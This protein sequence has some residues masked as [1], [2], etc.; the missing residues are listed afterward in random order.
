MGTA[1]LCAPD[2]S[3]PLPTV[4]EL[5]A[6]RAVR[7]LPQAEWGK[8]LQLP[9][10]CDGV[11][12]TLA[13]Q[14]SVIVVE[15]I[16][17]RITAYWMIFTCVHVE[18]LWIAPEDR[19]RVGVIRKL[20]RTVRE[21]LRAQGVEIAFALINKANPAARYAQRLGFRRT[22]GDC[23]FVLAKNPDPVFVA[24]VEQYAAAQAHETH[25]TREPRAS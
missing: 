19:G 10:F 1:A 23:Y 5:R 16:V 20:W 8:L 6:S 11:A 25:E 9:P 7:L 2:F 18:P 24:M 4:E 17:G 13:P 3:D 14:D 21:T 15:D 22:V 12:L